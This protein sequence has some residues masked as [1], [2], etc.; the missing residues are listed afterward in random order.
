MVIVFV[1]MNTATQRAYG[2]KTDAYRVLQSMVANGH[3]PNVWEETLQ[4]VNQL[5]ACLR[6]LA[7]RSSNPNGES[8]G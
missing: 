1:W 4:G 5:S 6:L 8:A 7:A 3:P 2:S